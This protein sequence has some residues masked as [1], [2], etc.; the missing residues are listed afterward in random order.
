MCGGYLKSC[1]WLVRGVLPSLHARTCPL[2]AHEGRADGVRGRVN[3]A[4]H[5]TRT[6]RCAGRGLKAVLHV[7]TV[8]LDPLT[9]DRRHKTIAAIAGLNGALITRRLLSVT[10]VTVV[11]VTRSVSGRRR[12]VLT[13][14][15]ALTKLRRR[16]PRS[17][18]KRLPRWPTSLI[19]AKRAVSGAHGGGLLSASV[20][21]TEVRGRRKARRFEPGN[22]AESC[23]RSGPVR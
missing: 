8:T 19:A 1:S 18:P 22:F 11:T 23:Q 21:A 3:V 16:L 2:Q 5:L 10:E 9:P 20:T 17:A 12:L 7:S 13:N 14:P 6:L 15:K 4:G